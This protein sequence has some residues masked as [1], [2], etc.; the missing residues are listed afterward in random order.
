M[1]ICCKFSR[2]IYPDITYLKASLKR[3]KGPNIF[4]QI[5]ILLLLLLLF[6][7]LLLLFSLKLNNAS[8]NIIKYVA[9]EIRSRINKYLTS[10]TIATDNDDE[11]G[12]L[13]RSGTSV[14]SSFDV[15]QGVQTYVQTDVVAMDSPLGPV[16]ANIFMIELENSLLPNLIKYITFWKRYVDDAI[17]FA[18]KETTE[19]IISVLNSFDKNIYV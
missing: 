17:C 15:A 2:L 3:S 13:F 8:M 7:L 9:K 19:F 4:K 5:I 12:K 18:K 14:L 16:L 11:I 1:N 10:I 6:L